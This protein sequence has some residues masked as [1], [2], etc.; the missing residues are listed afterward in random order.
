[1][2]GSVLNA[3]ETQ[4]DSLSA[5]RAHA[6]HY[7]LGRGEVVIRLGKE[8]IVESRFPGVWIDDR[9]I[10]I[11]PFPP[12]VTAMLNADQPGVPGLAAPPDAIN[13]LA[14]LEEIRTASA[15]W[16][17][18][19][20]PSHTDGELVARRIDLSRLPLGRADMDFLEAATGQAGI[21]ILVSCDGDTRFTATGLPGIWWGRYHETE[22]RETLVTIEIGDFPE[23]AAAA[24]ADVAASVAELRLW[25][26]AEAPGHA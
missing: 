4:L 6:F 9:K 12:R 2:T 10:V 13:G 11:A 15:A 14:V 19:R 24:D 26:A 20:S 8:E 5:E 22:G 23:L 16:R 17:S 3:L 21:E 7:W 25:L 18:C 1:M